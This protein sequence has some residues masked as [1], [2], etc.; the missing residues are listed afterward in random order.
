MLAPDMPTFDAAIQR[1]S[2]DENPDEAILVYPPYYG[3]VIDYYYRGG[4]S[5]FGLPRD[6]DLVLN[7]WGADA[8]PDDFARRIRELPR[9]SRLWLLTPREASFPDPAYETIRRQL[10]EYGYAQQGE[11][12]NF[13]SDIIPRV[14]GR[15]E[16]FRSNDG[17]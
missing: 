11:S 14:E 3:C 5:H 17:K 16:L 7:L 15:L 12:L 6:H 4:L 9:N 10:A 1:I 8:T 13:L 2:R